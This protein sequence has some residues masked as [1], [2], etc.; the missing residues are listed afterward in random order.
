ME[1]FLIALTLSSI[2][3]ITACSD[4]NNNGAEAFNNDELAESLEPGTFTTIKKE[5]IDF[6]ET[7]GDMDITI[8][9]IEVAEFIYNEEFY[10]YYD[11]PTEATAIIFDLSIENTSDDDLII[12]PAQSTI[13]TNT[14]NQIDASFDFTDT[15]FMNGE[16]FGNVTKNGKV[17]FLTDK[18]DDDIN[19]VRW[20]MN[21]VTNED[22]RE[23]G[24]KI[25][26]DI[27][28]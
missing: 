3:I 20:I 14:G 2:F 8:N 23:L 9:S 10:G 17:Y 15:S 11:G 25:D 28:L 1:K 26:L 5:D 13:T 27:D 16:F 21:G 18:I 4:Q 24:E 7:S 6:T 12:N 22:Y 19:S